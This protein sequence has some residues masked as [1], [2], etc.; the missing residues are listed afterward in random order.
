MTEHSTYHENTYKPRTSNEAVEAYSNS[1]RLTLRG[2]VAAGALAVGL[3]SGAAVGVEAALH[4]TTVGTILEQVPTGG[5]PIG[6]VEN[7]VH[8]L[9]E[10]F[11]DSDKSFNPDDVRGVVDAGQEVKG[12][13]IAAHP[14]QD[15]QPLESI[16]VT[17]SKNGFGLSVSANPANLS[18]LTK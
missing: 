10:R 11:K 6:A 14:G 5:T 8:D 3:A 9:A 4:E 1:F 16:E 18:H 12:E 15:V 13:L 17:V 7:G 2:K